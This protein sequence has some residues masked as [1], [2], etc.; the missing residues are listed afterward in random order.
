MYIALKYLPLPWL[1]RAFNFPTHEKG[2]ELAKYIPYNSRFFTQKL[3]E[4]A[5][6]PINPNI[7]MF[8]TSQLNTNFETHSKD[9][10]LVV[11]IPDLFRSDSNDL[12]QNRSRWPLTHFLNISRT[13]NIYPFQCNTVRALSFET[14]PKGRQNIAHMSR[15]RIIGEATLTHF[16]AANAISSA[17]HAEGLIST[18]K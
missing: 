11:N 12:I 15:N 13:P 2:R 5:R 6:L 17:T 8:K 4:M 18:I 14:H 16:V 10:Q 9:R 3:Q 7:N 1:I